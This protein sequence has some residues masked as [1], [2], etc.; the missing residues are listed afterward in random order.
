MAVTNLSDQS[1]LNA[2]NTYLKIIYN[3][4]VKSPFKNYEEFVKAV[5]TDKITGETYLEDRLPLGQA[6]SDYLSIIWKTKS[7]LEKIYKNLAIKAGAGKYPSKSAI[8][9]ALTTDVSKISPSEFLKLSAIGTGSAVKSVAQGASNI[10]TAGIS[11]LT[12][13]LK[14]APYIAALL[15]AGTLAFFVYKSKRLVK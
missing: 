11:G 8:W 13:L 9:T 7:G 5:F 6:I 10:A 1:K 15:G 3:N 14:Y 12:G 2:A 4:L